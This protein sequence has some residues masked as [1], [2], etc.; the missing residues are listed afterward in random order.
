MARGRY[1]EDG[2]KAAGARFLAAYD[3]RT[4]DYGIHAQIGHDEGY[5]SW[6]PCD[7]CGSTLGGTR[8]DCVLTNPGVDKHGRKHA[9]H[10]VSSCTD[11][12]VFAANGDLP[13]TWRANSRD[14]S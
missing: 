2:E 7:T 11:C 4:R 9:R 14:E 3:Q 10:E 1:D 12:L 6:S 8:Y 13:T 5:F